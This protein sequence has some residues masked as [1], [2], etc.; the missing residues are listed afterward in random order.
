MV[1]C[2]LVVACVLA[3]VA[4][5]GTESHAHVRHDSTH[6]ASVR[7]LQPATDSAS[8]SASTSNTGVMSA[9]KWPVPP[10]FT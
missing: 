9:L 1:Q 2:A 6:G 8:A 7:R 4:A 3:F 5:V 10:G